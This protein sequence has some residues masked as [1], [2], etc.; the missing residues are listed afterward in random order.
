MNIQI[1]A[2]NPKTNPSWYA[3]FH[4][5]L[6]GLHLDLGRLGVEV[7]EYVCIDDLTPDLPTIVIGAHLLPISALR[8]LARDTIIYNFEPMGDNSA[9]IWGNY[10]EK[11]LVLKRFIIWDYSLKNV[12]F[13]HQCNV[14]RVVYVPLAYHDA[15]PSDFIATAR[16]QAPQTQ[17]IDILF[18]GRINPHR[19]K[20]LYELQ[21]KGFKVAQVNAFGEDRDR[22]LLRSRLVLNLHFYECNILEVVRVSYLWANKIPVLCEVNPNTEIPYKDSSWILQAPYGDIVTQ[23]EQLLQAPAEHLQRAAEHA[24]HGFTQALSSTEILLNALEQSGTLSSG[25]LPDVLFIGRASDAPAGTLNVGKPEQSDVSIDLGKPFQSWHQTFPSQTFGEVRFFPNMF[26]K[27]I[28]QNL[29][30]FGEATMDFLGNCIQ[31]LQLDGEIQF[32][33]SYDIFHAM[34]QQMGKTTPEEFLASGETWWY[35]WTA[36][37]VWDNVY[38]DF[39]CHFYDLTPEGMLAH[40][41]G[42]NEDDLRRTPHHI[43]KIT[44]CFKKKCLQLEEPRRYFVSPI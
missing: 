7:S 43:D 17:D 34:S 39:K 21:E 22:Y 16:A 10:Y 26:S 25:H 11:M 36:D 33:M 2:P 1:L 14:H 30:D 24:Y 28:V 31:W 41:N 29:A 3:C 27:I 5:V 35:T 44:M 12:A 23:A 4:E 6:A 38:F 9:R 42:A 37:L 18:Y 20:I 19:A 8:R 15:L 32:S 40:Q 13:W